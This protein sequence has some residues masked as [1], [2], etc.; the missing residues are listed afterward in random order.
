M[1]SVV[2]ILAVVLFLVSVNALYVAAE[3][4]AIGSRKARVRER[5]E[6]GE[7]L[8]RQ[9][10]PI[11]DDRSQL[12]RYIAACQ[13]GI[14]L[15]S[16][17][18]GF[19]GQAQLTPIVA[20]LLTLLGLPEATATSITTVGLLIGLTFFQVL[21]GELLPKSI[22]IRYPERVA[23]ATMLPMRWSLVILRPFIAFLNG[24]GLF[25][26]RIMGLRA[27][28]E[29][30]HAHSPDELGSLFRE[31]A[32]G[33]LI[34]ADEQQM[35][36]NVLQLEDRVARQ[37]MIPRNRLVSASLDTPPGELLE[38]LVN[39][40]HTRFPIY[41]GTVDRIIGIVHLRDLYFFARQNPEGRL[42]E[43]V[44]EVTFVPESMPL[45]DLWQSMS[46]KRT[47][48][49]VIFDEHGGT[50]G[51]VTLEDLVEEIFGEVRDEFDSEEPDL[52]REDDSG[53][54]YMRGDLLVSVANSKLLLELPGKA[55]TVGGLVLERLGYSPKGGEEVGVGGTKLRVEA[56]R[57]GGIEEVSVG[58]T[59]R[60]PNEESG[61]VEEGGER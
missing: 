39:S 57:E 3:F 59:D 24:S 47:Y 11:L 21:L 38:K 54:T 7:R 23:L 29:H 10:L 35:L 4:A 15:S 60:P 14:T 12:D 52:I 6:G 51:I 46:E 42:D 19:Y 48:L 50:A 27:E 55:D 61:S 41:T 36:E 44:R 25:L 2:P 32:R 43:I 53:R 30:S 26:M 5:A 31:S 13:I 58:R 40:P 16:I 34:P 28:S 1:I 45:W 18:V 22:A 17:I 8:A 37:V 56:V 20:P 9:L 33:G 49:A